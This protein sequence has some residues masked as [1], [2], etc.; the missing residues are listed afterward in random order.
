MVIEFNYETIAVFD[1]GTVALEIGY[2]NH[3]EVGEYG[4]IVMFYDGRVI[5]FQVETQ[6]DVDKLIKALE[7]LKEKF[8]ESE[9]HGE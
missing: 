5:S 3:P 6:Q 9:K 8:E 1:D 7:K 2:G 4:N